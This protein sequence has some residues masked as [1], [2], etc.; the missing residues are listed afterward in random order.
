MAEE[1]TQNPEYRALKIM[2]RF[3]AE[4]SAVY[5]DARQVDDKTESDHAERKIAQAIENHLKNESAPAI[6]R[7]ATY[8]PVHRVA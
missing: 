7:N 8:L 4:M 3:I 2:E 1:L 6:V 5:D